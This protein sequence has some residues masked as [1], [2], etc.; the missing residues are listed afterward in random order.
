MFRDLFIYFVYLGGEVLGGKS[1]NS[2]R[3]RMKSRKLKQFIGKGA[4]RVK[5]AAGTQVGKAVHKVKHSKAD[6][7]HS[8]ALNVSSDEELPD[9]LASSFVKTKSSSSNKD[10]PHFT[11]LK[12]VQDIAVH[13]VRMFRAQIL[14][15]KG[16]GH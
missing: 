3:L 2:R 7:A 9:S 15:V 14:P 4:R 10:S 5:E 13:V 12:L 1:E 6:T 16:L 8:E 11:R